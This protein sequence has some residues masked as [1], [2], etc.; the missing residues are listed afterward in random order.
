MHDFLIVRGRVRSGRRV[1]LR[2]RST[3]GV[4]VCVRRCVR[5]RHAAR[6]V[7]AKVSVVVRDDEQRGAHAHRRSAR[8]RAAA[9]LARGV[10]E[11]AGV[12]GGARGGMP[13]CGRGRGGSGA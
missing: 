4:D 12:R 13:A 1:I 6:V 10:G 3:V 8:V 2:V 11:G 7:G 9:M 5:R